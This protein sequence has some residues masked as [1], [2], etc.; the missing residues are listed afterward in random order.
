MLFVME[1]IDSIVENGVFSQ[2]YDT[3]PHRC[4]LVNIFTGH[5]RAIENPMKILQSSREDFE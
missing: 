3:D 4:G 5:C 1:N 2:S